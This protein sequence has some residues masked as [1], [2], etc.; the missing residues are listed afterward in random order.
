VPSFG[1]FA[2]FVLASAEAGHAADSH[3]RPFWQQCAPCAVRYDAV[4]KLETLQDDFENLQ[5][6]L[7]EL[8]RA[9]LPQLRR[10]DR[11]KMAPVTELSSF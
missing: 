7:P 8:R 5:Q 4:I 3:W 11:S 1:Q 9:T 10:A 2:R 6:I